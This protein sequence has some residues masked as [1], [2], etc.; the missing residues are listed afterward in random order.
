MLLVCPLFWPPCALCKSW[1]THT[2]AG[3][4]AGTQAG[5]PATAAGLMPPHAPSP[6]ALRA[7]STLP[8]P[9]GLVPSNSAA[10]LLS[11]PLLLTKHGGQGLQACVLYSASGNWCV[12]VPVLA[13]QPTQRHPTPHHTGP[14]PA[15]HVCAV[16]AGG[17]VLGRRGRVCAQVPAQ[18]GAIAV[19]G[20]APPLPVSRWWG[21]WWGPICIGS[22]MSF[23]PSTHYCFGLGSPF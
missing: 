13:T 18:G 7:R 4:Q 23:L 2:A 6:C 9:A 12:H 20:P 11:V 19:H 17:C 16:C 8:P 5:R 1:L 15:T 14:L 22:L 3:A 10:P 21:I